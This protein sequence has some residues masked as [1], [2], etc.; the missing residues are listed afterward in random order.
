MKKQK[1]HCLAV[2]YS[3]AT[4]LILS[5]LASPA[6]ADNSA[7]R[8]GYV[9]DYDDSSRWEMK[10]G[11]LHFDGH[12]GGGTG[13]SGG[14]VGYRVYDFHT[15]D[16]Q[17]QHIA[18]GEPKEI[19]YAEFDATW[20]CALTGISQLGYSEDIYFLPPGVPNP[21]VTGG[22]E[23][24]RY[25]KWKILVQNGDYTPWIEWVCFRHRPRS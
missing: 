19:S 18:Y 7:A 20:M 3:I 17:A 24:K 15:T 1:K 2:M 11:S 12:R 22:E 8:K 23:G 5:T 21:S 16:N 25:T 14:A 4:A 13:E 6:F 9:F 10:A